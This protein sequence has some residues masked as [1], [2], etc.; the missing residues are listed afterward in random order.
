MYKN[1]INN[2]KISILLIL[3]LSLLFLSFATNN[4]S[5]TIPNNNVNL[6]KNGNVN[7]S[8]FSNKNIY[9]TD[10]NI[11]LTLKIENLNSQIIQGQLKGKII[12]GD[13]GYEI[14]CF[15]Y[16]APENTSK[17][18]GLSP[19]KAS[20]SN[21]NK[22]TMSTLYACSG[23]QMQSTKTL[24]DNSVKKSQNGQ[25]NFKLGPFTYSFSLNGTDYDVKSNTLNITVIKSQQKS[26]NQQQN[27]QSKNQNQQSPNSNQN[28]QQ[29]SQQNSNPQSQNSNPKN[30]SSNKGLNSQNQ[31]DLSNNQQNAQTINQIKKN[32]NKEKQNPLNPDFKTDEKNNFW[33][34][35]L[36]LMIVIL[37]L[38]ILYFKYFKTEEIKEE[39][40]VKKV[41][42]PRY[43][44]LLNKIKNEKE[45]KEKAKYLSQ[46]IRN[47]IANK[48]NLT[49]DLTHSKAISLTT[50]KL[51]IELLNKTQE[52]E[53]T[54]NKIKIDYNNIINKVKGEMK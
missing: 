7:L 51:F 8:L 53:F 43:L 52:I 28:Q 36:L 1:N 17:Y 27:Q 6:S 19:I 2:K 13:I 20:L 54:K 31:K 18:L 9:Q 42:I 10:E 50:N 35:F 4:S 40:K 41:E 49:D 37:S 34:W 44:I 45:D 14:Q 24:I 12:V 32:I 23:T 11:N 47:Y 26:Q 38:G 3:L 48:N 29:N 15:D 21:S 22:K 39:I 30:S 16:N 25:E 46:A 5:N 33:M